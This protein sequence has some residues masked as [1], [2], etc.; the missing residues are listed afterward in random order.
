MMRQRGP[1]T[2]SELNKQSPGRS[3]V[4]RVVGSSTWTKHSVTVRLP[5][6]SITSSDYFRSFDCDSFNIMNLGVYL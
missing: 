3:E 5:I 4:E 1:V 2:D 6:D